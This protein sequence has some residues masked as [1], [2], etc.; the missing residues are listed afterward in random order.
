MIF[1]VNMCQALETD[2][3]VNCVHAI[4]RI[5]ADYCIILL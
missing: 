2:G 3:V 4:F 5:Y 1:H